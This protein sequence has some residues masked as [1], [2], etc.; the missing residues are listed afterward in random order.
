[1]PEQLRLQLEENRDKRKKAK[2]HMKDEEQ[3]KA[4][5]SRSSQANST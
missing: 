3:R 1:M 4:A 2:Q 5:L